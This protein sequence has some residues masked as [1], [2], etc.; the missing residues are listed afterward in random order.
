MTDSIILYFLLKGPNGIER[1]DSITLVLKA[2]D[3]I[4]SVKKISL[5]A[6]LKEK[7]DETFLS[8][9]LIV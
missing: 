5:I 2:V 3:Y 9:A 1:I 4:I 8:L 7:N 6:G